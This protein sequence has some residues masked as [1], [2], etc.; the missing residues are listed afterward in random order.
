MKITR[1]HI[2]FAVLALCVLLIILGRLAGPVR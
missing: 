2:A 1:T